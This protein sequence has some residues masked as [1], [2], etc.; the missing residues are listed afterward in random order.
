VAFPGGFEFGGIGRMM[1]YATTAFTG[2]AGAPVCA[3]LDARGRG[4]VAWMP[5]HMLKAIGRIAFSRADLLHLNVAGRGSTLRKIVLSEVAARSGM[6]T[7]VHLHD[8][9]YEKDL[10]RRG[11][12]VSWLVRRM[13]RRARRVV[14]L[15]LRDQASVTRLLGVA[16]DRVVRLANAVPDPGEPPERASGSG[17]VRLLFLGH[18]DDR[19]G[20]PELLTALATERLRH[21]D[22]QLDLAGAGEVDRFKAM[23][24]RLGL[25]DRISFHGWLGHAD[26]YALSRRADIFVLPSHAEGQ[27]MS[28]IEAMAHGLAI[29]ATPVGAHLEAVVPDKEAL[30]VA[31]GDAVALASALAM[32]ID[33]PVQRRVLGSAARRRYLAGFTVDGYA[34]RL[35]AVYQAALQR[36]E[37]MS[38]ARQARVISPLNG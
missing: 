8:Y 22:W 16:P 7:I 4:H 38:A 37:R 2:Q 36:P 14:V 13:F 21:A 35:S 18:L 32:L 1:L 11:P 27:A 30:L 5:W 20:V 25:R 26:A 3:T 29:V 15:G 17:P 34:A 28:L 33:D 6:P 31:P 24:E 9:D 10:A 12:L 23:A 19:K